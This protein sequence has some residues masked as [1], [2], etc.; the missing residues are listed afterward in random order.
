MHSRLIQ[1][2]KYLCLLTSTGT[3]I[4][5]AEPGT[6]IISA[7]NRSLLAQQKSSNS[8]EKTPPVI[9]TPT[10]APVERQNFSDRISFLTDG[11]LT[12]MIPKGALIHTPASHRIS[13]QEKIQGKLVEWDEFFIANRSAIRLEPVNADQLQGI[14]P[15]DPK[16]MERVIKANLPTLASYQNRIVLLPAPSQPHNPPTA[17]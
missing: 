16:A 4:F 10:P 14:T 8:Y 13:V 6:A 7:M 12:V 1:L 3:C 9:A 5:A 2:F 15:L 17:P 11:Q